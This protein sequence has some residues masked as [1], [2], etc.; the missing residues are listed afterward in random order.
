MNKKIKILVGLS[1]IFCLVLLG[2]GVFS[3]GYSDEFE[4]APV[5]GVYPPMGWNTFK[6]SWLIGHQ[7]T[8]ATG[9]ILGQILA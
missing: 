2:S 5:G 3:R 9:S 4:G 6:A 7:V 1:S 8:S